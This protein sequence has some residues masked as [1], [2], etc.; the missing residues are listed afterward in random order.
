MFGVLNTKLTPSSREGLDGAHREA[1][2]DP[3]ALVSRVGGG[4]DRVHGVDDPAGALELP[5]HEGAVPDEPVIVVCD[6][7]RR[8]TERVVFVLPCE[9]RFETGVFL[10]AE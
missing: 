10:T 7:R 8:R 2:E 9:Q 3:L 4:V 1:R 5:A 6:P